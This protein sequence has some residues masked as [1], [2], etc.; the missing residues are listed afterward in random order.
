MLLSLKW[1]GPFGHRVCPC[2]AS[3]QQREAVNMNTNHFMARGTTTIPQERAGYKCKNQK[4]ASPVPAPATELRTRPDE[5][6]V[7]S[8]RLA[9]KKGLAQ[10]L[11]FCDRNGSWERA[12]ERAR[13]G[14][15]L[16]TFLYLPPP[17]PPIYV[18]QTLALSLSVPALLC[19]GID[20]DS[21]CQSHT[22]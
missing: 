5:S 16:A 13:S 11:W 8:I 10:N 17:G 3:V 9:L 1:Q 14:R 15:E 18:S 20:R 2:R 4:I 12:R 7:P 21:N 19:W 6:Q 22:A